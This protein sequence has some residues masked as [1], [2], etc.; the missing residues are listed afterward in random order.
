MSIRSLAIGGGLLAC[1]CLSVFPAFADDATVAALGNPQYT[2]EDES[3]VL[4]LFTLGNPA[5]IAFL[6]PANRLDLS[7][8]GSQR[9]EINEFTTRPEDQAV[10]LVPKPSSTR[11]VILYSYDADGNTTTIETKYEYLYYYFS[12]LDAD[13]NTLL[14][15]TVYSWK[16]ATLGGALASGPSLYQGVMLWPDDTIGLQFV[17]LGSWQA[18]SSADEKDRLDYWQAG[19][20]FRGAYRLSP[21]FALGAGF[22]GVQSAGLEAIREDR[23]SSNILESGLACRLSEVFTSED[24]LDFGLTLQGGLETRET[25]AEDPAAI[26]P[27]LAD[28]LKEKRRPFFATWNGLYAYKTLMDIS[29]QLKYEYKDA[30]LEWAEEDRLSLALRNL[31]YELQF[32]VRLPM[33]REDDLRFGVSFHNH[34]ID[35]PYPVGTLEVLDA[36]TLALQKPIRTSSSGIGIGLALV[37]GEGS[38]ISLEY[39]LGSCKTRQETVEQ[40]LADSGFSSFSLGAQYQ[41]LQGLYV[42]ASYMDQRL[43]YESIRYKLLEQTT[44][45]RTLVNDSLTDTVVEYDYFQDPYLLTESVSTRSFRFGVGIEEPSW[46]LNLTVAITNLAYTPSGWNIP[47]KPLVLD[48]VN[49]NADQRLEGMLGLTWMY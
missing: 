37:P 43:S 29:L 13:G 28:W 46:K 34:G 7:L 22:K 17:P 6:T 27:P 1:W 36:D 23:T 3:S 11:T 39:Q 10:R 24:H 19:G 12:N 26:D 38:L 14:P 33:A 2:L 32:R 25:A 45:T 41:V 20:M 15:N 31:D 16:R 47:E 18:L 21:A 30:F 48:N 8:Q 35:H 9:V 44:T 42:R 4:S 49:K 40:T 5:G